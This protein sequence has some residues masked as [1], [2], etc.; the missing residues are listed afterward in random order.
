[1]P[2]RYI[3][4]FFLVCFSALSIMVLRDRTSRYSNGFRKFIVIIWFKYPLGRWF[5]S[6]RCRMVRGSLWKVLESV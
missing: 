2:D 6:V 1:M 3:A 4:D 5:S